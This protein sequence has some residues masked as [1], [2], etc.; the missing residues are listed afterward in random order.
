MK[1][2]IKSISLIAFLF[3]ALTTVVAANAN[4]TASV[5][6]SST[7]ALGTVTI[8]QS[9]GNPVYV[10]VPGPGTFYATVNSTITLVVINNYATPQGT[11]SVA[12]LPN[13]KKVKT[14]VSGNIIVVV[15][16]QEGN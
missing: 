14:T 15:D 16:T 4:Y 11:S 1:N 13:G 2:Q 10:N 7:Q 12:I 3:L 5:Q 8:Q 6:N 9:S